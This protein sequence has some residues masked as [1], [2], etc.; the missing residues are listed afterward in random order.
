MFL[1]NQQKPN[2]TAVPAFMSK[3]FA[4]EFTNKIDTT[5]PY[6]FTS[7]VAWPLYW[8]YRGL[9]WSHKRQFIKLPVYIQR[10]RNCKNVFL[11]YTIL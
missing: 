5:K 9:E 4:N 11:T 10:V 2:P 7:L 6:I 8:L 3:N 1:E